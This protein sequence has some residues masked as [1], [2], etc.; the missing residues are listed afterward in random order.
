MQE[1]IEK[2]LDK[3]VKRLEVFVNQRTDKVQ[4]DNSGIYDRYDEKLKTIKDVC[5]QYFSKYERHLI[6]H[7][8][9]V[10]DLEKQQE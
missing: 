1:T 3:E 7:Q 4:Q 2:N 8:T 5:A 9:I 10:K 6:N